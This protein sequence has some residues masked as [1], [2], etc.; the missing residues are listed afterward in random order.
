[1]LLLILSSLLA[2]AKKSLLVPVVILVF[3]L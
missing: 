1:M 3:P 2:F